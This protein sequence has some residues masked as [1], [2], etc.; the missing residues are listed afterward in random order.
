MDSAM[1]IS[2][3]RVFTG[4][5]GIRYARG[6]ISAGNIA[7]HHFAV[8]VRNALATSASQYDGRA[9]PAHD[10]VALDSEQAPQRSMARSASHQNTRVLCWV[11]SVYRAATH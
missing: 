3:F 11:P 4:I 5:S 2:V 10:V 6:A 8:V 7:K 1:K 9:A